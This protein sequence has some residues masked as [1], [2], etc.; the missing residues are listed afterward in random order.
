[1]AL[2]SERASM[3]EVQNRALIKTAGERAQRISDLERELQRA[4]QEVERLKVERKSQESELKAEVERLARL[5]AE[6]EFY[7]NRVLALEQHNREVTESATQYSLWGQSLER[8]L[9]KIEPE[10]ARA[11]E[12]GA[13][14]ARQARTLKKR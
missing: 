12:F 9:A 14:S 7:R 10:G 5:K 1:M 8:E 2:F 11:R 4:V 6:H 3:L 13:W